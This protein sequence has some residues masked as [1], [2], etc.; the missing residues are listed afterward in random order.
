MN[1]LSEL[2]EI[3][4]RLIMTIDEYHGAVTKTIDKLRVRIYELEQEH[5]WIPVSERL[6][7]VKDGDEKEYD[8]VLTYPFSR[9]VIVAMWSYNA[10]DISR[11]RRWFDCSS[12]D[13]GREEVTEFVTHWRE[14]P[15][16]PEEVQE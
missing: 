12:D 11:K 3:Y 16:P 14:R 4:N 9:E 15:T 1:E 6:P 2:R 13:Y 7:E 5:R 8:V 10:G